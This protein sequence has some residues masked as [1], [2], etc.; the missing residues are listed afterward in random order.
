[1]LKRPHP[2]AVLIIF[3]SVFVA[4]A[5][6]LVLFVS[7]LQKHK[8]LSVVAD[9]KQNQ[10]SMLIDQ[11]SSSLLEFVDDYG[12]WDD[13]VHFIKIPNRSWASGNIEPCL[14]K[15][16]ADAIWIYS[17][18]GKPVY[19]VTTGATG[20]TA[21]PAGGES[22]PGLF[23]SS[24]FCHFFVSTG[25]GIMEVRGATVHPT[26]DRDRKTVPKGYLLAGRLWTDD[27]FASLSAA[28]KNR[29][30][31][32]LKPTGSPGRPETDRNLV[33]ITLMLRDGYHHP[34]ARLSTRVESRVLSQVN[35]YSNLQLAAGILFLLA[36]MG[37]SAV[38][39]YLFA[40]GSKEAGT[41]LPHMHD[42]DETASLKDLR[43]TAQTPEASTS[44]FL[45][46]R[47]RIIKKADFQ[48][49]NA[50]TLR[51]ER[52]QLENRIKQRMA[53]LIQSFEP[54]KDDIVTKEDSYH[55]IERRANPSAD[56][57]SIPSRSHERR[58]KPKKQSQSK[59]ELLADAT[60]KPE[61]LSAEESNPLRPGDLLH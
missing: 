53:E 60:T 38:L 3:L 56:S 27:T 17:A 13:L 7:H 58:K 48:S 8:L 10:L 5:G 23:A 18:E 20:A 19:T 9:D 36:A 1:M 25:K 51:M 44:E 39:L 55:G 33:A 41:A 57:G 24:R 42:E 21:S 28:W 34:V 30:D 45:A 59:Q 16:D 47:S 22:I 37:L 50:K 52:Y 29:I 4:V 32:V 54:P 46:M 6:T 15:Y 31:I 43:E 2:K 61:K 49:L 26:F 12:Y 14:S 11:R 40:H 35:L